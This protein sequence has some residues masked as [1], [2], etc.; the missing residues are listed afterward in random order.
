MGQQTWLAMMNHLVNYHCLHRQTACVKQL[1]RYSP[2]AGPHLLFQVR[3][4]VTPGGFDFRQLLPR[5]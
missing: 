4:L 5:L 1:P 3:Y 2:G